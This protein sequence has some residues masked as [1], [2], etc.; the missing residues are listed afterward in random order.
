MKTISKS[1]R[2]KAADDLV[3]A[4]MNNRKAEWWTQE[5]YLERY[6]LEESQQ[7]LSNVFTIFD[8]NWLKHILDIWV[9]KDGLAHPLIQELVPQGLWPLVILVELGKDLEKLRRLPKFDLLIRELRNPSK[10]IATWLESEIAAH[11]LR[12]KYSVEP[13]PKICGKV[14]DLKISLDSEE[15]FVEV[16]EIGPGE[17]Q[18][19]YYKVMDFLASFIM[20]NIP[21]GTSIE[22]TTNI[23]PDDSELTPLARSIVEYLRQ[24]TKGKVVALRMGRVKA[25][26]KMKGDKHTSFSLTPPDVIAPTQ[27]KRLSR[28][29]KHEARQIPSPHLGLVVLDAGIL[30]GFPDEAIKDVA[31]KTFKK[32]SLPNII[33]VAIVRSY[34]FHRQPSETQIIN[35]PNPHYVKPELLKKIDKIFTFSRTTDLVARQ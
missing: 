33:A 8:E 16:K 12:N 19:R 35:V 30:Q 20:P 27:L 34:K 24:Q 18:L 21:Q 10:F 5:R 4:I 15:V 29:I 1:E 28:S 7:A 17:M 32:Y 13:Y 31:V 22:V 14:P 2:R 25:L 9:E 6:P 26:L 23:L 3:R 11:C